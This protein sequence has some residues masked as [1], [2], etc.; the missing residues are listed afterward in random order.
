MRQPVHRW[1]RFAA[2]YSG[3]W[4]RCL[5]EDPS[6]PPDGLVLDPF[7]GSGTTLV[8]ADQAGVRSIGLEAHPFT[9]RIASAK[10][11][12]CCDTEA[13]AARSR[14]ILS[15][16]SASR[17]AVEEYTSLVRTCYPDQILQRLDALR[18]AWREADD[19]SA[20]SWLCWLA[21]TS[22]LRACSPV[23]T[24]NMELIQPKKHKRAPAE[25]LAA[26]SEAI[27]Q[28]QAD[29]RSFRRVGARPRA[30]VLRG[31]A[32]QCPEVPSGCADL[33]ITS[34]P[35]TNNF[36]YADALRLEMTFWGEVTRW[37]DL[38]RAVRR[39]L[40]VSCSQHAT[41]ERLQPEELLAR[42]E[43]QPIADELRPVVHE[44][45]AVRTQRGGQKHYH[46]MVAGY[47]VDMAKVWKE[48]R[49]ICKEGG[50][51]CMVVGDSAPYGVYVPVHRW[52]GVMALAAGFSEVRFAKTRDRNT[53]WKNRKHRVPLL[54]GQLWVDG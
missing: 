32:R 45:A 29:I 24:A 8:S 2:G 33:V 38:H 41:A 28:M 25:P 49:R 23:G 43:V 9:V 47:F 5:L 44:L 27:W 19:G 14:L 26:F 34:P 11:A 42:P 22:I 48:L 35:Y 16:A 30:A 12:W 37:G 17:G 4:V 31:D 1:F 18:C 46:T 54:E 36:D 52:L 3:E 53:K 39:H 13:I 20:A 50:R 7:C 6:F 10:L 21:L 40:L 15:R 51:V